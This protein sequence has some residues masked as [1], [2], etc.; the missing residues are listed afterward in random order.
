M[1]P[2]ELSR[3]TLPETA[4]VRDIA[5]SLNSS[6]MRIVLLLSAE[7]SLRGTV[8]D[9][10]VRRGLL[11]GYGLDDAGMKIAN[12]QF[13]T[14]LIGQ[15]RAELANFLQATGVSHL[16]VVNDRGVVVDLFSEESH[17]RVAGVP[18]TVVV[19]AG[20][21]G[22][23]LRPLTSTTPKPMLPVGGKPMLEHILEG[24]RDEG[25]T[26]VLISVN[27]LGE[28][29]TDY[30]GDGSRLGLDISYLHEESPLGTAG[31]LSLIETDLT[32]PVVVINGDVMMSAKLADIVSYHVEHGA[33][34]TMGVKALDTQ[35]PFGVVTME[36]GIVVAMEEK[37]TYRN[38]VNAGIYVLEPG[39]IRGIERGVRVDMPDLIERELSR[40]T[41]LAYPLHETWLDLG[42][43]EDLGK[44]EK[45]YGPERAE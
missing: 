13:R 34:I 9:G 1:L 39:I 22:M 43:P 14:A 2:E 24:I 16:P 33:T 23:R 11:G 6:G 32:D 4:S 42:H 26:T 12:T 45:S 37:P 31:A 41:V 29:I 28:Q 36:G 17:D 21:M 27:Y 30:F 38:Y 20:G 35:I 10:D 3:C 40:H 19:M 18:N 44:A 5:E 8:T 25:F 7:G 15:T